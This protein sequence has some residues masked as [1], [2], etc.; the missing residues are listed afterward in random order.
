VVKSRHTF[1]CQLQ[2]SACFIVWL[3]ANYS[4]RWVLAA[5]GDDSDDDDSSDDDSDSDDDGDSSD[6]AAKTTS[7]SNDD[8]SSGEDS[9]SS[10]SSDDDSDNKDDDDDDDDDDDESSSDTTSSDESSSDESSDDDDSEAE[11]QAAVAA[12]AE[13][14]PKK[15]DTPD[16]DKV[17]LNKWDQLRASSKTDPNQ[18]VAFTRVVASY[19]DITHEKLFDNSYETHSALTGESYG[20][21]A[22]EILLKTQGKSFRHEKTKK[23]RGTYRGGQISMATNSIK[24]D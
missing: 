9:D 6:D 23:K 21:K 17:V 2:T 8:D 19:D 3:A 1:A 18:N 24:F 22:A 15:L 5:D 12:A 16:P 11:E 10:D 13:W 4:H 7:K 14:Q 20:G